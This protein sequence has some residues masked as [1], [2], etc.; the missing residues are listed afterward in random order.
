MTVRPTR[1]MP[2]TGPRRLTSANVASEL[3]I[4]ASRVRRLAASRNL[5]QFVGRI[6]LFSTEDLE[7]MRHREGGN[8][9]LK[10]K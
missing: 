5:G 10:R 6:W 7:N 3:G 9:L 2:K 8:P 4:S 1:R